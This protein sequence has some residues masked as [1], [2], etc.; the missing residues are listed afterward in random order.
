MYV[1]YMK[2]YDPFI[3]KD[4]YTIVASET[5]FLSNSIRLHNPEPNESIRMFGQEYR[6]VD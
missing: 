6:N 1:I 2:V 4:R 5:D 3:M